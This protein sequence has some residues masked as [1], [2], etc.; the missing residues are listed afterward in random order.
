M[1]LSSASVDKLFISSARGHLPESPE[2]I[3]NESSVSGLEQIFKIRAVFIIGIKVN[4][5]FG[6]L[7][8]FPG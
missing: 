7:V 1:A 4:F 5:I 3:G 2:K 6:F 8:N